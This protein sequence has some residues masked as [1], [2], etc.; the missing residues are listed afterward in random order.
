M[1]EMNERRLV[2]ALAIARIP[3]LRPEERILLWDLVIDELALSSLLLG[4]LEEIV[5]RDLGRKPWSPVSYLEDA[6]RDALFL[7]RSG[8]RFL[9]YDDPEYPRPLRETARPPFGLFVRG[10]LPD[11][12]ADAVAVVGTRMPTGRGI[13]TAFFLARD[14]AEAGVPVVSGLARGIDAAAHRGSLAASTG[15]ATYAVLPCGIDRIYPTG[16]RPLAAAILESGGGL[17]S[18][19]PPGTDIRKYRF[20]ERN[21]IIAGLCRACVVVEAP[22]KSGALITAE[23]A[24]DEGRDV[25]VSADCL[26]GQRSAGIDRLEA[27]GAPA[28]GGA[29][30]LLDDWGLDARTSGSPADSRRGRGVELHPEAYRGE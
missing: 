24:L 11:P 30:Q 12:A 8:C 3:C 19:Y 25:W 27:D 14:L 2:L 15:G 10:S 28:L 6:S 29:A 17:V 1:K 21:R 22:A 4:E 7:E 20:P 26:A 9:H 13:D 23:H 5:G 18:E 16:N